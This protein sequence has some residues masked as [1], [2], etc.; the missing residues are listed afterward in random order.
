MIA[1]CMKLKHHN[2]IFIKIDTKWCIILGGPRTFGSR[3]FAV[4]RF[5]RFGRR[6]MRAFNSFPRRYNSI[7]KVKKNYKGIYFNFF[8]HCCGN[9]NLFWIHRY[10]VV[11][12]KSLKSFNG[13]VITSI[14]VRKCRTNADCWLPIVCFFLCH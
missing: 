5:P 1:P 12:L 8:I 2:E 11:F 13:Q 6:S 7:K 4:Q 14:S 3:G 10:I 9:E